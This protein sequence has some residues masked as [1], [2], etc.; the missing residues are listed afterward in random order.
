MTVFF[1]SPFSLPWTPRI[2]HLLLSWATALNPESGWKV[3]HSRHSLAHLFVVMTVADCCYGCLLLWLAVALTPAV[4]ESHLV[5]RALNL[6]GRLAESYIY[7][8]RTHA[9]YSDH[10]SEVH[11]ATPAFLILFFL[12]WSRIKKKILVLFFV[13]RH[14]K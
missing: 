11:C 8:S 3:R 9:V 10:Y 14:D 13:M 5:D 2:V 6:V 12:P 1:T 7:A 4:S